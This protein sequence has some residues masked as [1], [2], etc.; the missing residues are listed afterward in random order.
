MDEHQEPPEDLDRW[1]HARID[2]LPPPPGTFDLIRR[3][4]RRRRY[5]QVAVSAAVAAAVAAAVVVVPRVATSVLNVNQNPT[6]QGAAADGSATTE[7][8]ANQP[9]AGAPALSKSAAPDTVAP[10]ATPAPVPANFQATSVTFVG[11]NTG[12]VIG[13][14]GVPGHCATVYCTS[15]AR[16]NDAGQT[17]SG[18]HAPMTGAPSGATGVGQIR[19]LNTTNG[20]TFGP[21]LFSTHD[22]GGT[23]TQVNTGGLRVT[24]LETVGDR[25]FAIFGSCAGT[26]SSFAAQCTRFSLYSSPA[27]TDD[28][29]PV[30]G[31]SDL[32]AEL[33]NVTP[34]QVAAPAL[35][36]TPTKGYVLAA[37]GTLYG[38]A[39]D[40]SGTWRQIDS[41]PAATAG[42]EPGPSQNGQPAHLLLGA[43]SVSDL[44]LACGT[45]AAPGGATVFT[46]ADGG[47]AWQQ[48]GHL[49]GVSATGVAAQPGGEIIMATTGGLEVSQNGGAS[50]QRAEA[51]PTG[52]AGGFSWVGLTSSEQGVAVPA[53]PAQHAV[54]FT[55]DGGRTW[56]VSAIKNPGAPG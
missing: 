8:P 34:T 35:V 27:N 46:S 45:P 18:G 5:R 42:C 40:G 11:V 24:D 13:Q 39:V 21:E 56:G 4:V 25:A 23:W 52:P 6:S 48:A 2:P 12:W 30:A 33:A 29:Q 31:M 10:T 14:A 22:G 47:T 26:G 55:H 3:R 41:I 38:G 16:T 19:F 7:P 17:W 32:S 28:W 15:V 51:A 9:A 1:L 44:V 54:W 49:S 36:L 43:A 20:W 37:N 53:D 50:W